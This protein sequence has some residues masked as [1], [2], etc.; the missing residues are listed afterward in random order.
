MLHAMNRTF[1]NVNRT[2][3]ALEPHYNIYKCP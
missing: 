2:R 3:S 1:L